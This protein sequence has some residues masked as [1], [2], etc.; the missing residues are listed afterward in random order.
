LF[1]LKKLKSD[2]FIPISF[3]QFIP[4]LK[5]NSLNFFF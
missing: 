1:S 4:I 2:L 5:T 3:F